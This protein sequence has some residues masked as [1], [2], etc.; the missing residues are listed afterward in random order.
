[1]NKDTGS[2]LLEVSNIGNNQEEAIRGE[3]EGLTKEQSIKELRRLHGVLK[4]ADANV[5]DGTKYHYLKSHLKALETA[6]NEQAGKLTAKGNPVA[7]REAGKIAGMETHTVRTESD[8]QPM[9]NMNDYTKK[10]T[11]KELLYSI[12]NAKLGKDTLIFN[13]GSAL[14]CPTR[15]L[16]M[17]QVCI[18]KGTC[19]ALKAEIQYQGDRSSALR[20]RRQQREQW[21]K[22]TSSELAQQM[23]E[24]IEA[25]GIKY[26][27]MNESGDFKYPED[28][29]KVSELADALAGKAG[30][31]M[32]TGRTDLSYTGLSSN[33][34]INGS[35][36][37]VD[38]EFRF[39]PKTAF[40]GI[41]ETDN[42]CPGDCRYC[43]WCKVK[44]GRVVLIKQH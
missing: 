9:K 43:N 26:I 1:M 37:M 7:G 12:G 10:P 28:V 19:Y 36:F 15:K 22:R 16:G 33:L 17:C 20:K 3:I 30:V 21:T 38:N 34:T 4:T 8:M 6:E 29:N 41:K 31:Y 39:V 32:Y 42:V 11:P 27:R 13:M 44:A 24:V 40:S 5:Y 18:G 2:A 14:D 25:K 35:G 23:A